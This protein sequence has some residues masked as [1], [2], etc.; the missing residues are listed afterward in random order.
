MVLNYKRVENQ[1]PLSTRSTQTNRSCFIGPRS[2]LLPFSSVRVDTRRSQLNYGVRESS[3]FLHRA[4]SPTRISRDF[5]RL[6]VT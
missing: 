6:S 1:L 2:S 3:T 4:S 5:A